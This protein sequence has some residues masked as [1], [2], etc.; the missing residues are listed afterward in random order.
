MSRIRWD[1]VSKRTGQVWVTVDDVHYIDDWTTRDD[2]DLVRV[3][4]PYAR[5]VNQ[6]R[7]LG[8]I[9]AAHDAATDPDVT[10]DEHVK[11]TDRLRDA[12]EAARRALTIGEPADHG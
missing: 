1:V 6:Q 3:P 8:D 2:F 9:V 5:M 4:D 7:L 12:I 11:S 10:L